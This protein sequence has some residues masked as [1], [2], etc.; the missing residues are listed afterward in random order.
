MKLTFPRL[1]AAVTAVLATSAAAYAGPSSP[2]VPGDIVPPAG[3]K[4]FLV[5]HAEGVQI[6]SCNAATGA[7][8]LVAPRAQLYAQNG[9]LTGSHFVGPTWVAM[10]G[11]YVVG[12]RVNG[13]NVDP[14]AIDWLL[15]EKDTSAAGADGDR[16]SATTYI[17]RINTTGGRA[18]AASECDE[19]GETAEIPYAADYYFW[20]N[21]GK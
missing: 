15:L 3:N 20:K 1:A 5:T 9:K 14:T 6:Y 2:G 18:P 21:T 7:W 8:T 11:S 19:T 13:V 17:Q 4:V 10:D 16:L 12:R